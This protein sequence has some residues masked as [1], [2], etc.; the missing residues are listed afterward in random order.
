MSQAVQCSEILRKSRP[1]LDPVHLF[2]DINPLLPAPARKHERTFLCSL[3]RQ[4]DAPGGFVQRNLLVN[5]PLGVHDFDETP[6][7]VNVVSIG[8]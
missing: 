5:A 6:F 7:K 1:L 4:Q 3:M 2:L 8:V